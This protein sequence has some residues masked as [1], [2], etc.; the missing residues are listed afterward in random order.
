MAPLVFVKRD[1]LFQIPFLSAA[2]TKERWAK[3][4]PF[5]KVLINCKDAISF[6]ASVT[7]GTAMESSR[8]PGV[9]CY[10]TAAL[11]WSCHCPSRTEDPERP[12]SHNSRMCAGA[13]PPHHLPKHPAT[14]HSYTSGLGFR[15]DS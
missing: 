9:H 10:P 5:H 2:I 8:A 14:S 13:R 4:N 15:L 7:S 12:N 11:R 1:P 3:E 6:K